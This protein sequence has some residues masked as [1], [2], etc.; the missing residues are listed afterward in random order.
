MSG[1]SP[2]SPSSSSWWQTTEA[3]E[4]VRDYVLSVGLMLY[5]PD[6][7][8]TNISCVLT[9]SPFPRPLFQHAMNI[10]PA[11]NQLIESLSKDSD[12]ITEAFRK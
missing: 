3:A 6:V 7:L 10:Q 8:P 9:P 12:F 1:V 5:T 2:T 4:D 11:L